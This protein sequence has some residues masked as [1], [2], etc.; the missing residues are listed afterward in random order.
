MKKQINLQRLWAYDMKRKLY[1]FYKID[2]S[3]SDLSPELYA[4]TQDAYLAEFFMRTRSKEKFIMRK[5]KKDEIYIQM[6]MNQHRMEMLFMNVLT[7]G[8]SSFDFV[9]T[10]GEEYLIGHKCEEVTDKIPDV[11]HR[12]SDLPFDEKIGDLI[13]DIYKQLATSLYTKSPM[14]AFNTFVIFTN[15]FKDTLV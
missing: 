13:S 9:T 4:Y 6:F 11:V 15:L 5:Q 3:A 12:L 10:Y 8:V 1:M 2:P 14:G 7:D